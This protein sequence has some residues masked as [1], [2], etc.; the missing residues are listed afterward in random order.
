VFLSYYAQAR[1]YSRRNYSLC[2]SR[3]GRFKRLYPL[4]A[5]PD[6][7]SSAALWQ[8]K[9]FRAKLQPSLDY[10]STT[11]ARWWAFLLV[12]QR[13]RE[14]NPSTVSSLSPDNQS[15][16]LASAQ[17]VFVAHAWQLSLSPLTSQQLLTMATTLSPPAT[18]TSFA[19]VSSTSSLASCGPCT[20]MQL[21]G[22][23]FHANIVLGRLH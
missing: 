1:K 14:L 20:S 10:C 19:N 15:I 23:S 21:F 8:G 11:Y 3:K 17:F 7:E 18:F 16:S 12:E 2:I 6:L 13:L 9:C 4:P 5:G 22:K